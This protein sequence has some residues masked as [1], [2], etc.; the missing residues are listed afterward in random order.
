MDGGLIFPHRS[1]GRTE[2]RDQE[3]RAGC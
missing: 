1:W 2:W 3:G